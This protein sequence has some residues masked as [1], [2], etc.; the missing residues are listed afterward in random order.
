LVLSGDAGGAKSAYREFL[1]LWR[2]ADDDIPVLM[3][4]KAEYAGLR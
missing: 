3:Q 4:A 2:D 1:A